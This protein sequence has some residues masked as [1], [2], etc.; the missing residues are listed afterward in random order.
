MKRVRWLCLAAILVC[1]GTL[2]AAATFAGVNPTA[3][4]PGSGVG[5]MVSGACP[6]FSWGAVPG[7]ESYELVTYQVENE[8]AAGVSPADL[9]QLWRVTLPGSALSWTPPVDECFAH[10]GSYA[11]AIRAVVGGEASSWS[12]ASLFTVE[13]APSGEEVRK[14]MALMR[15]YLG[16][17]G[18]GAGATASAA[19]R[20][21]LATKKSATSK[22]HASDSGP[23]MAER[24]GVGAKLNSVS[25][26]SSAPL[27]GTP[28]LS[29]DANIALGASSN[30]FKN[31]RVLL[32]NDTS[33][34]AAFGDSALASVSGTATYDTA[35]GNGALEFATGGSYP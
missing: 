19:G 4:S 23:A 2:L 27:L 32:W 22:R 12:E 8:L 20:E 18:N 1:A 10:G 13:K 33:G 11:W 24:K 21:G 17:R 16:E 6:T 29:V 35:I 9:K 25:R 14:M 7:A 31:G 15:H 5:T 26:K 30:L 3:I 34:N 28:S